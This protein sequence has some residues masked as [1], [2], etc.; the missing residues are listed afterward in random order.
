MKEKGIASISLDLDDKWAFLKTHGEKTWMHFPSYFQTSIP[1]ILD[2]LRERDTLI[3]FFIIG[4]DASLPQ[5]KDLFGQIAANGHEIGNHTFHHDPWIQNYPEYKVEE[6]L[7]RAEEA[8][9]LATG[10]KT[11]G[12]RGPAFTFSPDLLRVLKKRNYLYDA[13]TLPNILNPLSRAYFFASS[14]LSKEEKNERSLVFGKAMDGFRPLDT[15]M[16]DLLEGKSLL[17]IPVTTFPFLRFP[18]HLTYIL[19]IG[20]YSL[21][22]ALFYFEFALRLCI[23]KN[24]HPSIL[25]SPT[26]FLG[27]EDERDIS[28]F[29]A[30]D[31][32]RSRKIEIISSVMDLLQKYFVLQTM[33]QHAEYATA[34]KDL[35]LVLP[36][37]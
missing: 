9:E 4:Q 34:Q 15:Y 31:I 26:D 36:K 25:L 27:A 21:K 22:L 33:K 6:E 2:F 11:Q 35:R 32:P 24:I 29:P 12:F 8:I 5:N 17:E 28:F 16:W 30:M 20:K 14:R 1:L 7:I 19:Y 18:I 10:K 13:S 37:R 3:T 23:L